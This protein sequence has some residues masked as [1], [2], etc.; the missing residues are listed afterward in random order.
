MRVGES[1]AW[2]G[3]GPRTQDLHQNFPGHDAEPVLLVSL[4]RRARCAMILVN[5]PDA[6]C[7]ADYADSGPILNSDV[8]FVTSLNQ[9][10]LSICIFREP[11]IN[12]EL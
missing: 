12:S 9:V 7:R 3:L 5:R 2:S 1:P 6:A 10:M 8:A 4:I 11:L